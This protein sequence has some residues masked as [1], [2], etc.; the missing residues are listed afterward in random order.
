METDC[1]TRA[2]GDEMNAYL[3]LMTMTTYLDQDIIKKEELSGDEL[4]EESSGSE[5]EE[6]EELTLQK[7]SIVNKSFSP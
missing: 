4:Q 1:I 6:E 3:E 2:F 5:E 7:R